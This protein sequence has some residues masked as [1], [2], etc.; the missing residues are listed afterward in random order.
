MGEV[1]VEENVGD[2]PVEKVPSEQLEDFPG[3]EETRENEYNE[4]PTT[5]AEARLKSRRREKQTEKRRARDIGDAYNG[6]ATAFT[7]AFCRFSSHKHT[8]LNNSTLTMSGN[9]SCNKYQLKHIASVVRALVNSCKPPCFLREII[10]DYDEFEGSSLRYRS[11]G[12]TTTAEELLAETG[13]FSFEC[14]NGDTVVT[15]KPNEKSGQKT[16]P[17]SPERDEYYKSRK[18]PGFHDSRES[19]CYLLKLIRCVQYL[20]NLSNG[21]RYY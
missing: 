9:N 3:F 12:Y 6:E 13:E 1:P 5:S 11:L 7:F 2:V 16:A 15:A 14:R 8:K 21:E 17:P 20:A 18:R 4:E 10:K 19:I